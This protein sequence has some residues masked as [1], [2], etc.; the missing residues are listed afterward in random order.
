MLN[1]DTPH[2]LYR[3]NGGGTFEDV[4]LEMGINQTRYDSFGATWGDSDH[5]GD[6]DLLVLNTGYG[7]LKFPPWDDYANFEA[8]GPNFLYKY[9]SR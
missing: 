9:E 7:P 4:S 2:Q 6:L 3:N 8:S 5:D 1:V